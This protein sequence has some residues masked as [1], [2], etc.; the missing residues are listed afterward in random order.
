M[1][2]QQVFNASQFIPTFAGF[3]QNISEILFRPDAIGAGSAFGPSTLSNVQI[4]L[5]T[6]T[7][8][9]TSLDTTFAN[10]VGLDNTQVFS[11]PLTLSS[12]ATDSGNGTTPAF[13][14]SIPLTTPFLYDPSQ[15][16][17]LMDIRNIGGGPS[18]NS[19]GFD[20][21]GDST[22]IGASVA[23][24]PSPAGATD[25]TGTTGG[26]LITQFQITPE[27]QQIPPPVP[28]PSQW[29]AAFAIGLLGVGLLRR[30]RAQVA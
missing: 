12:Q 26:F 24:A 10:N 19:L 11:G 20:A 21:V 27:G 17:L 16:N 9:S 13:D 28:E 5:S 1:R 7:S 23:S 6:T 15:G 8:S 2:Y 3:R 4:S 22:G 18:L 14:I 30:R 29:G 25:S